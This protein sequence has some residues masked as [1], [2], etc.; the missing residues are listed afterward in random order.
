[1]TSFTAQRR[2]S[3]SVRHAIGP[4]RPVGVNRLLDEL[5]SQMMVVE[6]PSE[7]FRMAC[8]AMDMLGGDPVRLANRMTVSGIL[9]GSCRMAGLEEPHVDAASVQ[10]M[11]NGGI[12]DVAD[13]DGGDTVPDRG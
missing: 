4:R 2:V 3:S 9:D 10:L 12:T 13:D 8:V 1:M 6:D 7:A 11:V 5:S